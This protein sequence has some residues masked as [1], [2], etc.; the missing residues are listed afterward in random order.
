M[1]YSLGKGDGMDNF[2]RPHDSSEATPSM[3]KQL[4]WLVG[5]GCFTLLGLAILIVVIIVSQSPLLESEDQQGYG[6]KMLNELGSDTIQFLKE[7]ELLRDD[8]Q[9]H[10]Y[11][12]ANEDEI[13]VV[14][15]QRV[16]YQL[17]GD[18]TEISIENIKDIEV[19]KISQS[20]I[21][22]IQGEQGETIKVE[23]NP[24]DPFEVLEGEL[25]DLIKK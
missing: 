18:Q 1:L 24:E 9:F 16:V 6:L 11:Y 19:T 21:L 8:E 10:L 22:T 17:S 15:D 2:Q 4:P 3:S 7:D 12:S 14:T 25:K 13:L 20:R 23:L 5:C